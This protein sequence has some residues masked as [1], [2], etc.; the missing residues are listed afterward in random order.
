SET[1]LRGAMSARA[2]GEGLADTERILVRGAR[3]GES[4]GDAARAARPAGKAA[5]AAEGSANAAKDAV[6]SHGPAAGAKVPNDV[7]APRPTASNPRVHYDIMPNGEFEFGFPDDTIGE[8]NID[9][10]QKK[11]NSPSTTIDFLNSMEAEARQYG[12]R[13]V[14][15]KINNI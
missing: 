12:V 5:K 11:P 3:A 13:S 14:T 10:I 8:Y 4:L 15:A 6:R 9:F 2:L 1:V 7:S